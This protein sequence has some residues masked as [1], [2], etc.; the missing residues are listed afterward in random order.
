MRTYIV[1]AFDDSGHV[2]GECYPEATNDDDALVEGARIFNVDRIPFTKLHASPIVHPKDRNYYTIRTHDDPDIIVGTSLQG[3]V[4]VKY[5]DLVE[6]FG[7]PCEG[8]EY[9]VDAEWVIEFNDGTIATIY[10]Y[11]DGPNYGEEYGYKDIRNKNTNW[12]VGGK[13]ERALAHVIHAL[14]G[15]E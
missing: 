6:L 1:T 5:N 7:E 4:D 15:N 2:L 10:N 12:H 11:K 13:N 14:E 3:Y 8:D 9:K